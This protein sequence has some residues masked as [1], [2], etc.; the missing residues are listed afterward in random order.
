MGTDRARG[1]VIHKI[2]EGLHTD[3]RKRVCVFE[4]KGK[5]MVSRRSLLVNKLIR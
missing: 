5:M 3:R 2:P 1:W 4:A